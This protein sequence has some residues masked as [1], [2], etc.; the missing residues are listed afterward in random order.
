MEHGGLQAEGGYA[1][2]KRPD[3][4]VVVDGT[5]MA[6]ENIED[7]APGN[8]D[9]TGDEPKTKDLGEEGEEEQA[10]DQS[11][12]ASVENAVKVKT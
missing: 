1:K 7:N 6:T 9:V 5:E 11:L 3:S 10:P 12:K 2:E 8:V 4:V